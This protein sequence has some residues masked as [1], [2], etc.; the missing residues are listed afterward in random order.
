MNKAMREVL[1]MP[2]LKEQFA[3][4]GV[5]A[6]AST[7]DELMSRLTSDIK[8]WDEVIIKAGIPKK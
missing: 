2:E 7:P 4:V 6:Q 5:V 3:K 1:A 8:K